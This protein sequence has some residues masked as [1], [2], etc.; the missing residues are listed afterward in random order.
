[1]DIAALATSMSHANLM[2]SVSI[3]V[4][5]KAMEMQQM[6]V[7]QLITTMD[8]VQN[9]PHPYLGASIDISI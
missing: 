7:E 8:T 2:Q 3:A 9:A 5:D 6:Q 4:T 1:M